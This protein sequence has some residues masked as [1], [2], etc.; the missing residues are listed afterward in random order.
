MGYPLLSLKFFRTSNRNHYFNKIF[1]EIIDL[2]YHEI[3]P[4]CIGKYETAARV[5]ESEQAQRRFYKNN[6]AAYNQ[7]LKNCKIKIK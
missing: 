6:E 1:G 3:H 7:I 5:C 2:T 4:N